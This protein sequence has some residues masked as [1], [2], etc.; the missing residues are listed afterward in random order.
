MLDILAPV[1]HA[2]HVDHGQLQQFPVVRY[3]IYA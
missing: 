3:I 1:G 2:S